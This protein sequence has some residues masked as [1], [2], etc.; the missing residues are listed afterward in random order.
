MW[1]LFS[2]IQKW[3]TFYFAK[4]F[5]LPEFQPLRVPWTFGAQ[6]WRGQK[7]EIWPPKRYILLFLGVRYYKAEMDISDFTKKFLF[8]RR[9]DWTP[10]WENFEKMKIIFAKKCVCTPLCREI[11]F[12]FREKMRLHPTWSKNQK[13]AGAQKKSF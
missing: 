5:I 7:V 10:L 3:T 9:S 13:D 11:F 1:T 2:E 12:Y 8:A 4:I 6:F